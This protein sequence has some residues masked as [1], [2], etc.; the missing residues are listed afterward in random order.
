M[1]MSSQ[2]EGPGSRWRI[3]AH[4][5][6]QKF[7]AENQGVVDELVVDDWLHLEQMAE[8]EWCLRLGDARIWIDIDEDGRPRVDIER[9][10]FAEVRGTT[11]TA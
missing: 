7:E 3:L 11:K 9:G 8:R 10:A 1:K 6:G 4:A 2:K 5:T